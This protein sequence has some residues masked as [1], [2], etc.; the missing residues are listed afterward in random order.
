LFYQIRKKIQL[1][2]A[3]IK[4]VAQDGADSDEVDSDDSDESAPVNS[5][6]RLKLYHEQTPAG[7]MTKEMAIASGCHSSYHTFLLFYRIV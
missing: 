6:L 2:F 3:N 1:A 5:V 7:Q 4:A